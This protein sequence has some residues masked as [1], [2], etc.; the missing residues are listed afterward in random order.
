MFKE[1]KVIKLIVLVGLLIAIL[2]K[3]D[4]S[5]LAINQFFSTDV[6]YNKT[7]SVDFVVDTY[8]SISFSKT[9]NLTNLRGDKLANFNAE[10]N[11][12]NEKNAIETLRQ[13]FSTINVSG[14]HLKELKQSGI[15]LIESKFPLVVKSNELSDITVVYPYMNNLIYTKEKNQSVFE[16]NLNKTSLNRMSEVDIFTRGLQ[17]FFDT[18]SSK[19]R[20]NYIT[21]IDLEEEGNINQSKLLIIYGKSTFWTPKMRETLTSFIFKGGNVLLLS[22]YTLNN[23]C[24]NNKEDKSILLYGKTKSKTIESWKTY[25]GKKPV[26]LIGCSYVYGGTSDKANYIIKDKR[27]AIFNGV[28]KISISA[29]LYNSPPVV[30]TNKEPEI[31][32]GDIDFYLSNILAY[33]ESVT[34][35]KKK[36]VKGIFEFQQDST[37]GKILNLGTQNWCLAYEKDTNIQKITLNSVDYLLNEFNK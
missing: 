18:I 30:W 15:Y 10:I 34:S 7:D 2:L 31:A 35:S 24:W 4:F 16:S 32:F 22:T 27:H 11:S 9:L 20:V 8:S 26:D 17:G 5:E 36:G 28:E 3:I 33:N 12:V 14:Y 23:V 6:S 1:L 25:N 13:G 29:P 37:S 19:Y 21:D